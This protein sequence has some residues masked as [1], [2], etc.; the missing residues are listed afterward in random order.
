VSGN[1]VPVSSYPS[2]GLHVQM[3]EQ[4]GSCPPAA[5]TGTP[6]FDEYITQTNNSFT[7]PVVASKKYVIL[8]T[9]PCGDTKVICKDLT[10]NLTPDFSIIALNSGCGA[11][12]KMSIRGVSNNF[13]VFPVT[14]RVYS[15][16]T[17]TGTPVYTT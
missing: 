9:S 12:E 8:L 2:P 11:D 1:S 5:P 3:W 6:I 13:V 4:T 15:G 10:T 16:S 14:V 7:L 17:A